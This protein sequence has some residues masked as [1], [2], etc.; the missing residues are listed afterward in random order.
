MKTLSVVCVTY[1]DPEGLNRTLGSLRAAG[2]SGL[3]L[4]VIVVDSSPELSR[5]IIAEAGRELPLVHI[6]CKPEGIYSAMNLGLAA[7]KGKIVWFLNGGDQ[8]SELSALEAG[9]RFM[10]ENRGVDA[11]SM[12]VKLFRDG[13]YRYPHRAPADW[14]EGVSGR[15]RFCHQAVLYRRTAFAHL[16]PY[17]TEYRLAADLD[18]HLRAFLDGRTYRPLPGYLVAYD[19]SGASANTDK[20]IR[21]TGLILEKSLKH[22]PLALRARF[23]FDFLGEKIRLKILGFARRAPGSGRLQ[24]LWIRWKARRA[25]AEKK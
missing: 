6:T 19:T 22:A 9:V 8:L 23:F 24:P 20:V 12:D 18:L 10:A 11:I 17:A 3:I 1:R 7:V 14:L 16:F 21:E 15:Q 5:Q 25:P 13:A 2:N 4:E